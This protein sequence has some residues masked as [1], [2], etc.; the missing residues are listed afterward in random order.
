[1]D[2][3]EKK[4]PIIIFA[5]ELGAHRPTYSTLQLEYASQVGSIVVVVVV[6][7]AATTFACSPPP[8]C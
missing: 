2:K 1:M 3:E 5:H 8:T 7:L 4:L 6:I